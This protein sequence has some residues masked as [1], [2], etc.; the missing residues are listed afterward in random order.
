MQSMQDYQK[1]RSQHGVIMQPIGGMQRL[2][3]AVTRKTVDFTSALL[4]QKGS[5]M[6]RRFESLRSSAWLQGERCMRVCLRASR[7]ASTMPW[8]RLSL[9]HAHGRWHA[10]SGPGLELW[11]DTQT[12][13][14]ASRHAASKRPVIYSP[15]SC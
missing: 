6:H 8:P 7:S 15:S 14:Q 9:L 11:Q 13:R 10:A 12:S 4:F 2:R 3:K 5:R 1:G